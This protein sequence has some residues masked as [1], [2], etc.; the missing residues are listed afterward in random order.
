MIPLKTMARIMRLLYLVIAGE[1]VFIMGW[2]FT[3]D[4]SIPDRLL[5]ILGG[6]LWAF[7][8]LVMSKWHQHAE[9]HDGA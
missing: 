8:F 1:I 6:E 2:L 3:S 4:L 7:V 9:A 5:I